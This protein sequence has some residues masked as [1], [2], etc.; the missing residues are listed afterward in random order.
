MGPSVNAMVEELPQFKP[1]MLGNEDPLSTSDGK[2]HPQAV[3]AGPGISP[4]EWYRPWRL[5]AGKHALRS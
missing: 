4:R 3:L 1:R 2:E 5:P